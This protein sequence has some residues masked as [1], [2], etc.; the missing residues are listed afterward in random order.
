[1]NG[2]T[3]AG[4]SKRF[5]ETCALTG[6]NL[7]IAPGE[8]FFLLGPSGCGKTTLLRT[9]AGL[10]MPDAGRVRLGTDD[11][12]PLPPHR[13]EVGLVFQN[14]A[15][16]PHLSVAEN[17]AFGLVERGVGMAE[18][19]NRVHDALEQV[20][21]HGLGGRRIQQ[22]SG[23]QQQRVALARAIVTRPRCLLLDEPLSS[24][25][26]ALRSELREE[27]QRIRREIG[28]TT[29]Y[30]THDREEALS[31]ADRIATMREGQIVEIGTPQV[32]YERPATRFTAE[33][34][35]DLNCLPGRMVSLENGI[36][37][38]QTAL[39]TWRVSENREFV[40]GAEVTLAWRPES[41]R[42]AAAT[43]T[44]R[45]TA[46]VAAVRYLGTSVQYRLQAT[47]GVHPEWNLTAPPGAAQ[48]GD[49]LTLHLETAKLLVLRA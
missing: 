12:T 16:W 38:V 41:W 45:I 8:L 40:N 24:L 11:V 7:E 42:I 35:G 5:G 17:I 34:L 27:I 26:A 20:R 22:L 25:D 18:R 37:E 4:V 29:L 6:V 44:Q 49:E 46:R 1:M 32:L 36:G 15:L 30:V 2:I 33:F 23:G 47:T 19:E 10:V 3:L 39:G 43:D 9:I 28:L 31:L 48:I 13:R 21:L 14:Y